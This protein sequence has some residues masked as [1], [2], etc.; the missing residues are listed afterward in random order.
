MVLAST[1][2]SSNASTPKV[3]L[4]V[5]AIVA[6]ADWASVARPDVRM[7]RLEYVVKPAVPILLLVAVLVAPATDG[8]V[9]VVAALALLFSCG[10]D[11]ALMLPEAKGSL[12][13]VG[14]SSF[15]VAQ[16]LFAVGFLIQPHGSLL[17]CIAVMVLIAGIP[18]GIVLRSVRRNSPEVLGPVIVYVA[19]ITLMAASA[20][21]VGIHD[22]ARRIPTIVG[23]LSF[24][25]SDLLLAINR[26]V[27]PLRHE[28]L[29]VHVTYH[30]A[31]FGLTIGIL[32]LS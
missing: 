4:L 21:A 16:V 22:P 26:F 8:A 13:L 19:A 29:I 15:L 12:F 23:G 25:A 9:Q 7:R 27:R 31:L 14:L 5:A 2:L 20:M 17:A 3:M 1:L 18:S 32:T 10:G 6:L 30:V 28:S 24:V 11:T